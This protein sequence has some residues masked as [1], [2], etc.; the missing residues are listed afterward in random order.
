[1]VIAS[2]NFSLNSEFVLAR[3]DKN[4]AVISSYSNG[5]SFLYLSEL[6]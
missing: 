2:G 5:N 3:N 4:K 6:A 1:M